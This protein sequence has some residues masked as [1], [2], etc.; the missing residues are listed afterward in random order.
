MSD[1]ITYLTE[2]V[3]R[4]ESLHAECEEYIKASPPSKQKSYH[5]GTRTG[6]RQ[7]IILINEVKQ[8]MEQAYH[9]GKTSKENE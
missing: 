6:I 7:A 3:S 8:E 2:L 1:S 4:L 5:L 9:R